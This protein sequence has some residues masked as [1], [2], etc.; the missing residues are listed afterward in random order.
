[1]TTSGFVHTRDAP[2]IHFFGVRMSI[3]VSGAQTNGAFCL[4]EVHSP[5][6]HRTPRHVHRRESETIHLLEGGMTA[7][8]DGKPIKVLPGDTT[9]LP[10]DIPHQLVSGPQGARSLLFCTPSGF[11]AFVRAVGTDTPQAP[12]PA[13]QT[14]IVTT[15]AGFGIEIFPD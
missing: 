6:G 9:V 7:I 10:P 4:L 13:R 5:A 3:L 14:D 1:M 15:A 8:L 11:D 12:D 2:M